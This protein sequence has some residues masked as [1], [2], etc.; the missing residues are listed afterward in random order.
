[1]SLRTRLL[2]VLGVVAIVALAIADVATY[3]ALKSFLYDQVDR[4]LQQESGPLAPAVVRSSSS[5]QACGIGQ[6]NQGPGSGGD[7]FGPPGPFANQAPG[8]YVEVRSASGASTVCQPGS[9]PGGDNFT[10]RLPGDHH[11]LSNGSRFHD[12][13]RRTV[14]GVGWAAVPG[15]G[16]ELSSGQQL[17][18]AVPISGT[19][20]TLHRLF[21]VEL[22]VSAGA[23][24]LVGVGG[25]WLVRLG[26]RPWPT[27]NA[28]PTPS[29]RA[30]STSASRVTPAG[31]RSVIW[32]EP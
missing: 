10:P 9:L 2:L 6:G 5:G 8:V 26:L 32:L 14:D 17:I 15:A 1:M 19:V 30:S 12:V 29:P 20:N 4:S 18:L 23:V 31:P 25:F 16:R 28:P 22:A 13:L 24:L 3:S 11:G 21:L 7:E 27:S